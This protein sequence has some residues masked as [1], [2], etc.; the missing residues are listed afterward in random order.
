MFLYTVYIWQKPCSWDM[1]RNTPFQA[2]CSIYKRAISP[3]QMNGNGKKWVWS[4]SLRES[5]IE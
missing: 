1:G 2:D 5:K 3:E 4:I